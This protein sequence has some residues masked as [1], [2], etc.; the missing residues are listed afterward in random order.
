MA[1]RSSLGNGGRAPRVSIA[2]V[3][4][5]LAFLAGGEAM[6]AYAEPGDPEALRRD[7]MGFAQALAQGPASESAA[8]LRDRIATADGDAM[9]ELAN[10][11]EG[12]PGW[13]A[14]TEAMRSFGRPPADQ[15]RAKTTPPGAQSKVCKDLN[16]P[17][18]TGVIF[19]VIVARSVLELASEGLHAPCDIVPGPANSAVCIAAAVADGLI[20]LIQTTVDESATCE[21]ESDSLAHD[22]AIKTQSDMATQLDSIETKIDASGGA[23]RRTAERQLE[24]QLRYCQPLVSLVLPQQFGGALEEVRDLVA[25][26]LQRAQLAAVGDIPEATSR[27]QLGNQ[28]LET[29]EY[30]A[31]YR[32]YCLA[33]R[34]LVPH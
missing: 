9:Q 26:W 25:R 20:T 21:G 7:L 32:S 4:A 33:Y 30:R 29:H 24:R 1:T 34:A 23:A 18:S 6:K 3:S 28:A 11:L 17:A 8:A 15:G 13:P 12:Q 5:M 31:A 10:A 22:A 2:L 14:A 16:L 19:G 27:L